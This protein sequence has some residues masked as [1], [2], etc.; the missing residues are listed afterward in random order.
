M[1]TRIILWISVTFILVFYITLWITYYPLVSRYDTISPD[2][3]SR[4]VAIVLGAAM[5]QE[6]PSPALTERL[7]MALKLYR[8]GLV[9]KIILSGGLDR[10]GVTEAEGMRRYLVAHGVPEH[11]LILEPKSTNTLENLTYSAALMREHQLASCYLVTHDY[12]MTRALIYAKQVGLDAAPAPWHT[13]VLFMPYHKTR[14]MLA[15]LKIK[16]TH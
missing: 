13:E 12:H 4:S 8:Q 7:E 2:G 14:E 3:K 11:V 15:L 10:V 6:G 1:K 9:P 16:W 5:H